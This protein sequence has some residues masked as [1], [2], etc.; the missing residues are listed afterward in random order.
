MD[1]LH[2]ISKKNRLW[3]SK[4]F[5][6]CHGMVMMSLKVKYNHD[7]CHT[8]LWKTNTLGLFRN[9]NN[10]GSRETAIAVH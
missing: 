5:G 4:E 7:K 10:I 8:D 1:I 2:F 3:K 6:C 9:E